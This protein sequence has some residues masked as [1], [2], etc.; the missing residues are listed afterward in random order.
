MTRTTLTSILLTALL[1]TAA[2]QGGCEPS[3]PDGGAS[4]PDSLT[5]AAVSARADST[6]RFGL[7]LFGNL[8]GRDGGTVFISPA[9]IALCLGMAYNGADGS[10][11]REMAGA[12]RLGV[13]ELAEFNAASGALVDSLASV[14]PQ[15]RLDIANSLWLR[16]RFPFRDAFVRRCRESFDAGV[17]PLT[18][19]DPINAWVAEKTQQMIPKIIESIDARDIAVLVNAIYFKG[20]WAIP[21][22]PDDTVDGTFRGA[23]GDQQARMMVREGE[24]PYFESDLLQAVRLP[25]GEGGASMYVLLPREEKGIDSLA[26]ALTD[27]AWSRWISSMRSR[28]GRLELPRFKASYFQRLNAALAALGMREAF[29]SR[30][31]FTKLCECGVGDVFIS[32]V[33]HKAVIEVTEEGTEAAAATSITMRLTSAMPVDEPFRMIVDRPFLLAIVDGDTGLIL[34][35]GTIAKLE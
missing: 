31:D 20:L 30:A 1:S 24:M 3:P 35:L 5:D 33:F 34:F 32:D 22:D 19:A 12:L 4:I 29:T 2:S 21:F 15:I 13:M 6:N 8:Y 14:D 9:S 10:T 16:E 11:A 18:A 23:G 27:D 28:R 25:Y 17:F 26:A 7:G